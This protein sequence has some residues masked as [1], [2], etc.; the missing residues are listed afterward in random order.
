MLEPGSALLADQSTSETSK[1]LSVNLS[2]IVPTRN[3][4]QVLISQTLPTMFSQQLRSGSFEIVVVVDGSTD[5]TSRELAKLQPGNPLRFIEQANRGPSTARNVGIRAARGEYILFIDD[6][7]L[8]GPNLFQQHLDAHAG[9]G[10][11]LVYGPISIAPGTPPSVLKYAN[12]QWYREYYGKIN[13]QNGVRLPQ[14]DYLISN[15]S[16]PRQLLMDCGGFDETMTAKEDYELGLR[17]WNMG[18]EFKYVREA[19]AFEYFQKSIQYVLKNDGKA[20]GETDVLLAQKFPEYRPHSPLAGLGRMAGWK[21]GLRHMFAVLPL[22]PISLLNGPLWVCDRL[23]RFP[24]MR[25]ISRYLLGLGRGLVEFRSAARQQGSWHALV[26]AF[27]MR[28]PV[29]LYHH[30]GPHH[31]GT[32]SG[33]TVSPEQFEKHVRW[34]AKRGYQGICPA[35]WLKW[36][37]EGTGLPDKPILFT[38]DDAYTDLA[39]YAFPILHRYGFGASV[40]VVTGQLGGT[41]AW[42]EARGFG[43]LDL[44]TAEQIREW[45]AKGIEFG[46]HSRTHANLPT[47]SEA[48]LTDE[49]VGS[50]KDL[51]SI[52]GSRVISFAYP[53]GFHN[54]AVDDCVRGAFDLA[55]IADDWDE[56]LNDLQTDPHL[57]RRTM[58]QTK[59]SL[60]ALELRARFGHYPL[61]EMG[62]RLRQRVALRTRLKRITGNSTD[63]QTDKSRKG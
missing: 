29:L 31:P 63:S 36:R 10:P 44:M 49:V 37:R 45:S 3:R 47:L 16:M 41:N 12:E 30:V 62:N 24:I 19:V 57:L 43:T 11:A 35:D 22:N 14:D 6:D 38:F 61:L 28:L 48:D 27:G 39:Q 34:L 40:Y 54:Q 58:V 55:F 60:L 46:A 52:L 21:R 53:Y 26:R 23:C 20:F 18:I 7:I 59:D 17:L 13:Q 9:S 5:G 8:C 50:A 2:I 51:A 4:C 33:L 1:V 42:D 32:I 56:G 25:K 15:S